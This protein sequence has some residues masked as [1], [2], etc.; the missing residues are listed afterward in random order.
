MGLFFN[1]VL[2]VFAATGSFLFGYD[3]GVMT[4]VI[5]SPNFL[6]YFNTKPESAI[7]G[8]I[9]ATFSGGAVFGSFMSVCSTIDSSSSDTNNTIGADSPW[10]VLAGGRR[11][12]LE[13]RSISLAL[14]SSQQ[15]KISPWSS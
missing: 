3:S 13:Q 7:I 5:Q 4:L 1:V 15:L 2:A 12:W 14:F 6:A 10:T 8:A 11:S 9:N